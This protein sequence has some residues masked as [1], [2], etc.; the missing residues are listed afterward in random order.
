MELHGAKLLGSSYKDP[1]TSFSLFQKF[2][3]EHPEVSRFHVLERAHLICSPLDIA[4]VPNY[5]LHSQL[6]GFFYLIPGLLVDNS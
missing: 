6:I 5:F 4:I 1:I 3:V 2:S